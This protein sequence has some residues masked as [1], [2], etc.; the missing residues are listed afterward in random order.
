[1]FKMFVCFLR[2]HLRNKSS[3]LQDKLRFSKH[4]TFSYIFL[5][6]FKSSFRISLNFLPRRKL[7]RTKHDLLTVQ[8]YINIWNDH[9]DIRHFVRNISPNGSL[10]NT[11]RDLRHLRRFFQYV[12]GNLQT[13]LILIETSFLFISLRNQHFFGI[14]NIIKTTRIF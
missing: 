1:M 10:S 14:A 3:S 13:L 2:S 11:D 6:F 9:S 7:L 12:R 8:F 5:S 4:F